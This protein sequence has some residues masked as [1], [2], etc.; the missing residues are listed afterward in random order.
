MR[1]TK[2]RTAMAI[3]ATVLAATA[4]S[5]QPKSSSI[6]NSIEV[7]EL[8][9]RAE[10]ADHARLGAHFEGLAG[11]YAAE[12]QRHVAMARSFTGNPIRNNYGTGMSAHC[13]QLAT[14]NTSSATTLREL[15]AYHQKLA[16]GVKVSPPAGA[17]KFEGGAGAP[18]PTDAELNALAARANTPAEHRA[19]EEYFV[20]LAKRHTASA[21]DHGRHAQTYRGTRNAQA[22][23]HHD[24][25][26]DL[27]RQAA[28]EATAA[29]E[30]HK[31]LAGV[32][33]K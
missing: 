7:T 8:V 10:P 2:I 14:L 26:A 9:K 24:R 12:A 27:E 3:T 33:G 28:K 11:R 4:V 22:A 29:A 6:L 15:A 13:K 17:A 1:I 23:L 18:S 25:L 20:T 31:G 5:A 16:G 19:I 32:G 30:M 21:T